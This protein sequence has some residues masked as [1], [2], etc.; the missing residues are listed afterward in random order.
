[1][2]LFPAGHVL[3]AAMVLLDT[4]EGSVLVS[5]DVSLSPSAP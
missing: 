5:G 4:P 2:T 1:V 3:G